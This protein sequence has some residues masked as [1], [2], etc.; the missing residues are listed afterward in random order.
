MSIRI[1]LVDDHQIV[2]S[3]LKTLLQDSKNIFVVAEAASGEDAISIARSVKPDIILMD[4]DM[5]GIGGL[6]ATQKILA[7]LP[8]TK[9]IMLTG[10]A[11]DILS[12]RLLELGTFGYLLKTE[13]FKTILKAIRQVAK[14]K[15]FISPEIVNQIAFAKLNDFANSP[16]KLLSIKELLIVLMVAQG[17]SVEKIANCLHLS[18][19]TINTYRYAVFN[20]LQVK[21]NV[22]ITLMAIKHGL[23]NFPGKQELRQEEG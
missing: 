6:G 17:L 22:G 3:G 9:V 19:K 18:K 14:G 23:I 5:P 2:R 20:K 4:I 13:D 12:S 11:H 15:Y 16:F 10:Y 7:L 8:K 1:M 21:N